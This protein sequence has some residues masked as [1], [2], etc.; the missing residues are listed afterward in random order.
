MN[1]P[2]APRPKNGVHDKRTALLH[3]ALDL[4]ARDGLP[5]VPTSA[6]ARRAGVAKGTLFAYFETKEQLINELYLMIVSQYIRAMMHAFDP[7][8][9]P[10]A[11]LRPYWFAFAR[12]HLDHGAASRVMLQCEVSSVLT[13]ETQARKI[14]I[15]A[16][17][18]RTFFPT[19]LEQL[20]TSPLRYVGYAL[21]AGPI[22]ILAHMRDKGEIEVTDELLT[23]TFARVEKALATD[24]PIQV[25]HPV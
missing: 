15:E 17:V 2:A 18:I 13:A 19:L 24:L 5:S 14:E 9:A 16:E 21:I 20:H 10:N 1:A 22:Q 8:V 25:P 4:F 7:S 3:A 11:R 12:W 6:I 23:L